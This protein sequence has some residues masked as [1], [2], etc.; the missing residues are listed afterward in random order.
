MSQ[1]D[2]MFTLVLKDHAR[3]EAVICLIPLCITCTCPCPLQTK[4]RRIGCVL[5]K[6]G[7]SSILLEKLLQ[8]AP[9]ALVL[10][11]HVLGHLSGEVIVHA[12]GNNGFCL[13]RNANI[14][15]S[16]RDQLDGAAVGS[17]AGR[18]AEDSI[19]AT[20]GTRVGIHEA[21]A[22]HLHC[23]DCARLAMHQDFVKLDDA[24]AKVR[25]ARTTQ[26][27]ENLLLIVEQNCGDRAN[28]FLSEP[29]IAC[30]SCVNLNFFQL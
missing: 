23:V 29:C 14:I 22:S 8:A 28:D 5:A 25:I 30:E 2:P 27:L 7:G 11:K 6:A 1:T 10:L 13:R 15:G 24:V 17:T 26:C 9:E 19:G 18:H 3:Y 21:A 12:I 4:E 20:T 16:L